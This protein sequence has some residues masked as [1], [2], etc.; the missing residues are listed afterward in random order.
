MESVEQMETKY[1]LTYLQ[2]E[3]ATDTAA[4]GKWRG[5]PAF[6][7]Q[8]A[9]YGVVYP[10][11]HDVW[12]QKGEG[13]AL[14]GFAGGADGCGNYAI[15]YYNSPKAQRIDSHFYGPLAEHEIIFFQSGGGGGWGPA[16]EREPELVLLDVKNGLVSVDGA[17]TDYGVV[18]DEATMR[19]DQKKTEELRRRPAR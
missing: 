9:P 15:V 5:A 7:M 10:V 1:P 3:Y 17:R 19:V 6:H 18:I 2:G 8:R 14:K 4:P 16:S 12:I 11:T 13:Y